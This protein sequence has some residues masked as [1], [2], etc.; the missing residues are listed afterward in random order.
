MS[1]VCSL[2]SSY[3][4]QIMAKVTEKELVNSATTL[5]FSTA[6]IFV[7]IFTLNS[8]L[9]SEVQT[10]HQTAI[11]SPTPT[12]VAL[13]SCT[14]KGGVQACMPASLLRTH[15]SFSDRTFSV[16]GGTV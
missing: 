2:T 9:K 12:K 3:N 5:F 6:A 8:E 4:V 1:S 15:N 7:Y 13:A 11:I 14:S 16:A 10:H